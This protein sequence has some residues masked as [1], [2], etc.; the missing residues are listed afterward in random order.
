MTDLSD[1]ERSFSAMDADTK[2]K[3]LAALRSG[4]Y[5]RAKGQLKTVSGK[6]CCL[7]VLCEVM[8]WEYD[9]EEGEP[10]RHYMLAAGLTESAMSACVRLND[11]TLN[12]AS[13]TA[14]RVGKVKN[15]RE[16]KGSSFKTIADF[17]ERKL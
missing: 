11:G 12:E 14:R 3:W 10:E 6:Y 1:E 16:G 13:D 8:N 5:R 17:I 2:Q 4:N 15:Y 9:G 7:G